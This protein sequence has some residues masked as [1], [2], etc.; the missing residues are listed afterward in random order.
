MASGLGSELRDAFRNLSLKGASLGLERGCRLLVGVAA[1]RVL[2]Q[3]TFGRFV[4]ASTVTALLA[5]GTDLGLGVWTTR[6]L[7]RSRGDGDR[8]VRV[9]LALRGLAS[10]PYG[11]AIAGIA[12][13]G[14]RGEERL[15]IALLGVAALVNAFV[16]HVGAVLRGYERFP[17]EARLNA[18]RAFLTAVAGLVALTAG[19]SLA[20]LCAALAAAGLGALLYGLSKLFRLHPLRTESMPGAR[21]DRAMAR[22]ALAQSLPIWVAGLVSMLYFKVDTLFLRSMSGDAELGAYGAAFKLF[23]GAMIVPAILLAVAFPKLARAHTDDPPAQG[24]LERHLSVVLLVLGLVAGGTCFFGATPLIHL[25]F[26]ATF[27]RAVDSV[28]VLALGLPLL[29]VNFGMTHFL[30]ARDLGR[31]TLWLALM[32]LALNVGLD[33]ALIPGK[34]GPGA[35]WATVLSEAALT[36]GCIVRLRMRGPPARALPSAPR[37]SRR[38]RRA[39]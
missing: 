36:A 32:M 13:V 25:I 39:A 11:L 4:F 1:A 38:D 33:L 21:A 34:S 20:A 37:E 27:G 5:L 28:R 12:W 24:R 19:R 30:V 15:A 8:V 26:G 14:V 6:A 3:A 2:G 7:A 16:D 29:Y 31:V 9:G 17:D 23:E 10:L 18:S 22:S 35:A